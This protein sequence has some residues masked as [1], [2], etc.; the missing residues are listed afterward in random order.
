[1]LCTAIKNLGLLEYTLPIYLALRSHIILRCDEQF[2]PCTSVSRLREIARRRGA[3][4]A[5]EHGNEGARALVTEIKC[6]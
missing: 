3:E 5:A 6:H 1:M 4:R 2:T